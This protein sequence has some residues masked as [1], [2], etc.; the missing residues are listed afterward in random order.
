MSIAI[1][2]AVWWAGGGLMKITARD[3]AAALAAEFGFEVV[4]PQVG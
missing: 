3:A 2:D 1:Q 4:G